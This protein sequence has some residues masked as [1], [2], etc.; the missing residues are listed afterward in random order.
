MEED[1][2]ACSPKEG[3]KEDVKRKVIRPTHGRDRL[4]QVLN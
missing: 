3:T 1:S 4:E 2:C